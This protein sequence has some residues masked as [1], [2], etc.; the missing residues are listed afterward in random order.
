MIGLA[1]NKIALEIEYAGTALD[2]LVD[3]SGSQSLLAEQGAKGL[4]RGHFVI[5]DLEIV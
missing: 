1:N 4:T 3:L 2:E 5:G